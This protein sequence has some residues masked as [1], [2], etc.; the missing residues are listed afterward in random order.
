MSKLTQLPLAW[1]LL[2]AF[3][4]APLVLASNGTMYLYSGGNCQDPNPILVPGLKDGICTQITNAFWSF[5]LGE[6]DQGCTC[7]TDSVAMKIKNME[8]TQAI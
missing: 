7:M 4:N 2:L 8:L 3:Q 1:A 6:L 5:K